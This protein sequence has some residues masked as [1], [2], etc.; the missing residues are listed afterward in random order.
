MR[1]LWQSLKSQIDEDIKFMAGWAL[2]ALVLVPVVIG[3]LL[4]GRDSQ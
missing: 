4:S 1:S 2:V 3:C